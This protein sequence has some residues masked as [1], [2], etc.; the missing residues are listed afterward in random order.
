MER[1]VVRGPQKIGHPGIGD[2]EFLATAALSIENA[3]QQHS[4]VANQKT[5]GLQN[6]F[7]ASSTNERTDHLAKLLDIDC[8]V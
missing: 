5:P 8:A 2:D 1:V 3:G 4:G 7:E 6:Y